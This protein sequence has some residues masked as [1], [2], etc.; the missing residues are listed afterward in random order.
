[1]K[2]GTGNDPFA[3]DEES[4]GE[5]MNERDRAPEEASEEDTADTVLSEGKSESEL[6]AETPEEGVTDDSTEKY[7]YAI[8]RDSVKEGRKSV[9]FELRDE[10]RGVDED[11]REVLAERWEKAERDIAITDVREA[12]VAISDRHI[13]EIAAVMEEWGCDA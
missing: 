2:T 13:D 1:M 11:I 10:Y 3:D 9:M 8:R 5:Q 6:S 4:D 12:M 7:P